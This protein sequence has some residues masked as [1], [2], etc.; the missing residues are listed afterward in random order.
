[1]NPTQLALHKSRCTDD[2]CTY[3]PT[4]AESRAADD[5][6]GFSEDGA[7]DQYERGIGYV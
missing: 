7:A 5:V 2:A 1:M 4:L 6:P 3:C